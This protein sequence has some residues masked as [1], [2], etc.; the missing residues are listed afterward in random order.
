MR[1][2][3]RRQRATRRRRN[4]LTLNLLTC[5]AKVWAARRVVYGVADALVRQQG[6]VLA[7][8]VA[9]IHAPDLAVGDVGGAGVV[10]VSGDD[11][12]DLFGSAHHHHAEDADL[13]DS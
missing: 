5:D 11:D 13:F 8:I 1:A 6:H 3:T 10:A 7:Q 12:E 9:E 2:P 4:T